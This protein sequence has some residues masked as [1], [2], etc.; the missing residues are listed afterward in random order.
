MALL[1][2]V[3]AVALGVAALMYG[4]EETAVATPAGPIEGNY[5]Y[6]TTTIVAFVPGTGSAPSALTVTGG[7]LSI[8]GDA[9]AFW[10]FE[11]QSANTPSRTG[12]LSCEGTFNREASTITPEPRFGFSGFPPE[13]DKREVQEQLYTSFCG[14][15]RTGSAGGVAVQHNAGALQLTGAA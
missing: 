3:L 5:V 14:L 7:R 15:A 9:H 4:D 8:G 2:V 13:A 11:M 1:S 6:D 10:S 12:R